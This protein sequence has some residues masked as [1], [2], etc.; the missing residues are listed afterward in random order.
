MCSPCF[1]RPPCWCAPLPLAF[2]L[3]YLPPVARAAASA[4]W[5]RADALLQSTIMFTYVIFV[6]TRQPGGK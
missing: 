3:Q 5:K 2:G 1:L 4:P 6:A